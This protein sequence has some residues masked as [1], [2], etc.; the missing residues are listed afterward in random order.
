MEDEPRADVETTADFSEE[1]AKSG[2][3]L[4]S[5][6][7]RLHNSTPLIKVTIYLTQTEVWGSGWRGYIHQ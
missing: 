1:D 3:A 7:E 2:D 5:P 4:A 6:P